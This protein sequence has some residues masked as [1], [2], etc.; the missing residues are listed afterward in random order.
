MTPEGRVK[1]EI[2]EWLKGSTYP[3]VYFFMPVQT[4]YGAATIDI[5]ACIYGRFI[6][7]ETKRK[8]LTEPT[9]RQRIVM[10]QIE[11]AGGWAFCVDS[12]GSFL[13]QYWERRKDNE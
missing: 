12:L 3:P 7:I 11:A 1:R 2:K 10:D 4:G 5:L 6:G 13:E 9:A 8:G